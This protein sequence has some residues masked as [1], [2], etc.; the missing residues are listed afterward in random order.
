MLR[1][2]EL[3]ECGDAFLTVSVLNM[4]EVIDVTIFIIV[5]TFE[6]VYD[7]FEEIRMKIT[8]NSHGPV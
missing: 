5:F 7:V 2:W 6:F 1:E 4:F 8:G 3:S